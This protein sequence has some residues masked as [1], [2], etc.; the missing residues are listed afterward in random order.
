VNREITA[1]LEDSLDIPRLFIEPDF[2][3]RPRV[4]RLAELPH[5]WNWSLRL[6]AISAQ[7]NG[8]TQSVDQRAEE[9]RADRLAALVRTALE[10]NIGARPMDPPRWNEPPQFHYH[11]EL[12]QRLSGWYRDPGELMSPLR[13]LAVRHAFLH[14]RYEVAEE[15]WRVLARVLADTV[16]PWIARAVWCLRSAPDAR[17]KPLVLARTMRIRDDTE[18]AGYGKEELRRLHEVKLIEWN[19]QQRVWKLA[20]EYAAG[21]DQ[22]I[23]GHAFEALPRRASA[24][25]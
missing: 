16:P 9:M 8:A 12:V 18:S 20:S 17:V 19:S 21:I 14:G 5:V 22:V 24:S 6:H 13:V 7:P 3:R 11:W 1:W 25:D 15:D 23:G 2:D 4:D 10:G